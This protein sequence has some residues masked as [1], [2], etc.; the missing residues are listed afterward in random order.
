[1]IAAIL[2]LLG[3]SA[4]GSLIG[5]AFAFMNR[6]A[7]LQMKQIELAHDKDRWAHDLELRKSDLAIAN[8]EASATIQVAVLETEASMETARMT[9]I[10]GAQAGDRIDADAIR[11][12]GSWG[13]L[14]VTVSAF[15]KLIRPLLT[16]MLSGAAL[17]VNWIMIDRLTIG[18]PNLSQVQQFDA[19]MQA[20]SW[21]TA[22]ASVAFA[23]W[24]V[25]RGTSGK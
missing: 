14:L 24:F 2:S 6:K 7:D 15:N 22:Q 25:A 9:A 5:G 17:Y 4:I 11:E 1:M 10:A 18:W 8:A 21:V 16:V 12:A 3:S 19:G 13:W 20:F 23:Y